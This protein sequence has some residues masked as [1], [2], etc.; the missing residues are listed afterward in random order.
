MATQ[1]RVVS[2]LCSICESIV[3]TLDYSE[4]LY[5]LVKNATNC[6]KAKASSIRL[7]DRAGETLE[8]A[9]TF[10][11]SEAYLNKGPV[12]IAKDPL[13]RL[14]L[15]GQVVQIKDVT[16][17]NRFQYPEEAEKEGIKS[18]LCLPLR[19]RVRLLGVLRIYTGKEH[20]FTD[21]EVAFVS[22]LAMQGGAVIRNA[23]IYK[24]IKSLNGIGKT[25]ASHLDIRKVL[26]AIC[27]DAAND[28]SAKGA[29]IMLIN[30]D[31]GQLEITATFG[32]SERF[33]HKGHVRVDESISDCLKGKDIVIEDAVKNKRIQYPEAVEQEGIKSI[34]CIPL[35]LKDRIIGTLRIY[36]AYS[37]KLN[38]EDLEFL[39]ILAEFGVVAIE[40]ARLYEH[41]KRDY[42]DL[43]KDVWNWYAWGK[44]QPRI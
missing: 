27:Y 42:E 3:S 19:C 17:D 6:L 28:M 4:A 10:G 7:L 41:I 44:R 13:D 12:E 8:I 39:D 29:V 2:E 1:K 21:E 14:I 30:R 15:S 9:A 20:V 5:S 40:N 11:L 26:E 37:Y 22:T 36:T 31:T 38:Q 23:Q 43:T 16:K 18:I 35:K 32:L 25:I 34:I 33:I 24:R